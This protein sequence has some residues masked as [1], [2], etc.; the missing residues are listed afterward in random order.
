MG[1]PQRALGPST[2][3]GSVSACAALCEIASEHSTAATL[4][5]SEGF[6]GFV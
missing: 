4:D 5:S 2:P 6:E 1:G 3:S